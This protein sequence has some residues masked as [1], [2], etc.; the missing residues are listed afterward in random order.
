MTGAEAS[1][2]GRVDLTILFPAW[3]ES[4]GIE[5]A[6][7]AAV[8]AAESLVAAGTVDDFEVLVVDDASTDTTAELV[9]KAAASDPRVRLERHERNRKLGG[10]LRT[11]FAAARGE[12]VVYT[13]ADLP[14]D[15]DELHRAFRLLR[16]HDADIVSAFR[17]DRAGEG[18]RRLVYSYVYNSLVHL[19]VG[20]R[21]RDV[22]FA[23][24]LI[25][26]RVLDAV[27]LHSEGSFIDVELLAKA[28]RHGFRIVQF[29]VDYF[30][31]TRGVSTLSSWSVIARLLQEMWT[32][33]PEIRAEGKRSRRR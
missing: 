15:L 11:G 8:E 9:M 5:R 3:N 10:A 24:K 13:D 21:L 12:Y 23:A 28:E 27:Q 25:R 1:P 6:L 22:N 26:R 32:I 19:L 2:D 30:P 20:L 17:N 31:R 4:A 14:F 29:G 18:L 16:H 7:D 33:L